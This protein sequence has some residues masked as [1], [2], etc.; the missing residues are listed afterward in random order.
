MTDAAHH[1]LTVS[2]VWRRTPKLAV[3][4]PYT[5]E[6]AS[7]RPE[8]I[9]GA[10][11]DVAT[12]S[13]MTAELVNRSGD[14]GH[15]EAVAEGQGVQPPPPNRLAP[16][17]ERFGS[18]GTGP[19]GAVTAE[20]PA[21][22]GDRGPEGE[23]QVAALCA[24][25]PRARRQ[26]APE[27]VGREDT[28]SRTGGASSPATPRGIGPGRRAAGTPGRVAVLACVRSSG[29]HR[30][31]TAFI[32]P[33]EWQVRTN[34]ERNYEEA[35]DAY[36]S[37]QLHERGRSDEA[38]SL[39]QTARSELDLQVGLLHVI[40][41][42]KCAREA[43]DELDDSAIQNGWLRKTGVTARE[44]VKVVTLTEKGVSWV[45]EGESEILKYS[46]TDPHRISP[47]TIRHNLLAQRVTLRC[48]RAGEAIYYRTERQE[49]AK[50]HRNAKQPDAVWVTTCGER[51]G[52][53]IELNS[54]MG[55]EIS[56][57]RLEHRRRPVDRSRR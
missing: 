14:R 7:S 31:V 4:R 54:K 46:E 16:Q 11:V 57:I 47:M 5:C 36:Q 40:D 35:F 3:L 6:E 55:S 30:S 24:A 50:S 37:A 23:A 26:R 56:R 53:E 43:R 9:L 10:R 32:A 25:P 28:L 22:A 8:R 1:T 12:S 33:T 29:I 17:R 21:P 38:R 48:I 15:G 45:E 13:S 2:E 41:P 51:I 52:V 18:G 44:R 42:S 19:R 27:A 49:A 39:Q 20:Q 34:Y